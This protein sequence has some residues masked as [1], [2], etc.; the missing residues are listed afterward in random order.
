MSCIIVIII[1]NIG[2]KEEEIKILYLY[3]KPNKLLAFPHWILAQ[4]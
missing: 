2:N 3:F 1:E 4:A